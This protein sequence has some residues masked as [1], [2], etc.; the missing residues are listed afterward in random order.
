[1]KR[2]FLFLL[3]FFVLSV[4]FFLLWILIQKYALSILG[5]IALVPI[6]LLGYRPTGI[7]VVGKAIRFISATPGRTCKCD[8]DLAP[9][10]FI[11]FLS[12]AFSFSPLVL[13]RRLRA[14]GLGLLFLLCFHVL[15]LSLRVLLFE[16]GGFHGIDAYLIRFL[17]PAGI[18]LPVIL[19]V[20]LFPTGLLQFARPPVRA[21]RRDT[22][23]ICG[24]HTEEM[25]VHIEKAHGKGRSGLKS[26]EA[27]CY[28]ESL[29]N[30]KGREKT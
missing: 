7:E 2:P 24:H 3:K 25:I 15:Y 8:V 14:T 18:L 4:G 28:L 5:R 1:M 29:E 13:S 20:V 17:A 26:R 9:I 27:K 19:W 23:P 22:C 21:F 10:G 16:P 12:L 11:I 6:T 30:L